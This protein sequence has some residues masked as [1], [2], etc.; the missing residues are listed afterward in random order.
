MESLINPNVA[1]LLLVGGMILAI[2]ALFSPGTGLLE[3][4]A[5]MGLVFGGLMLLQLA[6]Q[7]NWWAVALLV[8]GVIP[9]ILAVRK[10]RNLVYLVIAIIAFIIGSAYLFEGKRWW[11]PGVNPLL[12]VVVS[13]V[14][15]GYLWI[16][17]TKVLEADRV[18]PTHDLGALI[19]SVGEA[20]TKIND[21]GSV[22][23]LGELWSAH[24]KTPIPSGTEVRV[25]GR[26]GFIL[27]VEPV[28]PGEPGG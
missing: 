12:A 21:E 16:A 18:R 17:T 24:S 4:G 6:P 14:A 25:I 19:G 5:L 9:F 22:Q 28:E 27:E 15:G 20:K 10:S 13:L 2:T 1:Y 26:E 11:Q 8:L 7:V 3:L 23:V